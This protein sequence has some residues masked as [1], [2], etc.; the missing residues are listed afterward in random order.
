MS[1]HIPFDIQSEIIKR[2]HVKSLLQSKSVCIDILVPE[3]GYIVVGFGVCHD[4]SDPKLVKI[5]VD[6]ISSM[7]VVEVF[8]LSTRVWKTVY[9]GVPFKSCTLLWHHVFSDGA[10]N[11][12]T[13]IYTIKVEGM[14]LDRVL[15]FR[16]NGE[17]VMELDADNY[18]ESR[19]AVY[20]PLS[21]HIN[22]VGINGKRGTF[23]ARSYMETLLLLDETD[24]I[25]H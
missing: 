18:K 8:T 11:P 25:I 4:T 5:Y 16:N 17:V 14:W 20:E 7:W 15:G 1:D 13:K 23:Y 9:M 12:F 24:S 21:G 10:N 22:D 2:L 6:K 3:A 19:I